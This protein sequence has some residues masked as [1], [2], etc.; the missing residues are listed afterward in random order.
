MIDG[1]DLRKSPW[2]GAI[3]LVTSRTYDSRVEL[4]RRNRSWILCVSGQGSVAS[5]TG[6]DYVLTKL[7]LFYDFCVAAFAHLM[8]G[9][10]NR[11]RRNLGEGGSAIVAIL[12]EAARNN[13]GAHKN[14]CDHSN[15]HDQG[16]PNQVFDVL[17]HVCS[18]ALPKRLFAS[19]KR[20][21]SCLRC[22]PIGNDDLA[23]R[24][25]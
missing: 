6:N 19:E 7:F 16:Q 22:I 12:A 20:Y 11:A 2:L 24:N 23:H 5:F 1:D 15:G 25:L 3:S 8:S 14:E 18:L 10:R 4:G 17:E 13:S 21:G 9:K